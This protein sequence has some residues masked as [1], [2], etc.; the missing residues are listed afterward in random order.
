V[1][2]RS[3]VRSVANTNDTL[4]RCAGLNG[5]RWRMGRESGG[6]LVLD[7]Y[8]L[9]DIFVVGGLVV[10]LVRVVLMAVRMDGVG[11]VLSNLVCGL[12]DTLT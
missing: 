11:Y 7:N 4:D 12:G 1:G 8:F 10:V 6:V 9:T 5:A 3:Y 2:C